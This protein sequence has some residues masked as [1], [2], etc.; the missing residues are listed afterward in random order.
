MKILLVTGEASGDLHG[1]RLIHEIKK[2]NPEIDFFAVGGEHI[3]AEDAHLLFDCQRLAVVGLIEILAHIG[4]ILKCYRLLKNF[5]KS[6]NPDLV[7]L[8]DYPDFN[9]RLAKMAKKLG[10]KVLYYISPQIWA[11]RRNRIRFISR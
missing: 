2:N 10:I 7:I 6:Q 4:T 9:L 5:L 11:W 8:I 3:R 1:A